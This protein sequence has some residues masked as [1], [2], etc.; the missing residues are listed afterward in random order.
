MEA[1]EGSPDLL[2]SQA[3]GIR[4]AIAKRAE[5]AQQKELL[6]KSVEQFQ[7]LRAASETAKLAVSAAE[8][9]HL[10]AIQSN[11]AD[12]LRGHLHS[13][14]ECP[15]CEQI[16]LIVPPLKGG[17]TIEAAKRELERAKQAA[18]DADASARKLET[19][20]GTLQVAIKQAERDLGE[21]Q[22]TPE[23]FERKAGEVEAARRE[24]RAWESKVAEEA[25]AAQ[26]ARD[27]QRNAASSVEVL[28]AKLTSLQTQLAVEEPLDAIESALGEYAAG[29][30]DLEA[31]R[32]R[33]DAELRTLQKASANAEISLVE[34]KRRLADWQ[35]KSAEIRE[36]RRQAEV[37]RRLGQ[38][39]QQNQ[40]QEFV[41]GQT[42]RRLA[43]EGTRQLRHLSSNRYSFATDG[44]EFLVVDHWNADE[45]RS[46]NTL[47][48][49]ES[50]LASLSLALAL[51]KSLP[52][53]SV[54]RDAIRLDSLFLD[55]GF[56]TLDTETMQIVLDAIEM[57]QADGRMIGV[58]SH[59]PELAERLPARIE[60]SKAP[61][62]STI[63]VLR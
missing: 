43:A 48:G 10:D 52:D 38:L 42:V 24:A 57:L 22:G 19:K 62:S 15:V 59:I 11:A 35:T 13:G 45:K 1:A 61:G 8:A 56:S 40:F 53:F 31:E 25:K 34:A 46:V 17:S 26:R 54:N 27:Q 23:E 44:S 4:K 63:T 58:V 18:N 6:G 37:S 51:S 55:E 30:V 7:Q 2:R 20:V 29:N 50:F 33:L 16:V 28:K 32:K 14:D 5:I 3:Q 21:I 12:Q 60:V 39:L 49:G 47:S 41:L 9:A 36:L